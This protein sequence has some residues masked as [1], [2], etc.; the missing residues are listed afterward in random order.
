M[1]CVFYPD[2][3]GPRLSDNGE[4]GNEHDVEMPIIE[5]AT[6]ADRGAP[7]IWNGPQ[8]DLF[9]P[10]VAKRLRDAGVAREA[11][12]WK[13]TSDHAPIWTLTD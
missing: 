1:P 9:D 8:T 3:Y 6:E 12:S 5:T 7:S 13:H 11:R 2:L 10:D 4:E